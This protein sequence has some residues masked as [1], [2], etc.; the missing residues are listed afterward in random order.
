MSGPACF[1]LPCMQFNRSRKSKE[2]TK[3]D[4]IPAIAPTMNPRTRLL[5]RF[6]WRFFVCD[7][8]GAGEDEFVEFLLGLVDGALADV[9]FWVEFDFKVEFSSANL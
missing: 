9:W 4:N 8:A 3:P 6:R 7:G 2:N 5:V 1:P